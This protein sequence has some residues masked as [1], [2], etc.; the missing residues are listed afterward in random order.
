M[1]ETLKRYLRYTSWPILLAMLGLIFLG[2]QAI[3]VSEHADG[4]EGYSSRQ[5]IYA[6]VGLVAFFGMTLIPYHKFGQGAYLLYGLTIVL[7]VAVL[8]LPAVRQTHRWIDLGFFPVQV[9]EIAKISFIL[10]L[11]WYLRNRENYRHVPGLIVPFILT[12]L[13]MG[14]VLIEPDLGTSLLFLPTLYFMLFMAGAKIRHLLIILGLGLTVV[15]VPWPRSVDPAAFAKDKDHFVT[16]K[17]G[18]VTL[19]SVDPKVDASQ[20]PDMPVAYCRY[21]W[22]SG[23]IRDLQPLS[24]RVL[25]DHQRVRIEAWLRPDDPYML[26]H[27]GF[28]V[29]QSKMILGAGSW[30]GRSGWN[31]GQAF[32]SLLP[33]DHT[34]F[35]L[36]V[37]GGQWGLVGCVGMLLLYAVIFVMGVEIAVITDDAFGRLLAVGVLALL[38]TQLVVNA[39]MAMGLMPVTGMTL[40]FIS[41]GGSSLIINCAALGMLVN[42]GQHRPI[43]MGPKPFEYNEP[44]ERPS[45]MD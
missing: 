31:D 19:Y 10:M 40:P 4:L 39:G 3:R 18:P 9:S 22:G 8:R 38:F 28:Q 2:I 23:A 45:L 36:A 5:A 37:V 17:L 25:H 44:R 35:I 14:L 11:A 7:L 1:S 21:Q 15:L 32:F 43:R 41:Y 29:H 24:L 42:V 16:S 13:P 33:E 27:G 6:V 12:L 30:T 26:K 20:R 34:D